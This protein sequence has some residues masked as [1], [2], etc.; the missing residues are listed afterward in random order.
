MNGF[1]VGQSGTY[2]PNDGVIDYSNYT[3]V[4]NVAT[5]DYYRQHQTFD[6]SSYL[7]AATDST[8]SRYGARHTHQFT[9]VDRKSVV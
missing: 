5:E 2:T 8:D 9:L 7:P 6:S 4:E 3:N 1:L